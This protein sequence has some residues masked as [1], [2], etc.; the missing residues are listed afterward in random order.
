[1]NTNKLKEYKYKEATK[2]FRLVI[3]IVMSIVLFLF[4]VVTAY[5]VWELRVVSDEMDKLVI[6]LVAIVLQIVVIINL[7]RFIIYINK[8]YIIEF[9]DDYIILN[10]FKV[11][12]DDIQFIGFARRYGATYLE[13]HKDNKYF[14]LKVVRECQGYLRMY[15]NA[16]GINNSL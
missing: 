12:I 11:M 2:I 6:F 8:E 9:Y 15:C 10:G 13:V 16:R 3:S 5:L 14:T 7:L 1:V 4:V